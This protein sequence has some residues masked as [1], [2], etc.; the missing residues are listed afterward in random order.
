MI[1]EEFSEY[2][3]KFNDKI[4]AD[5]LLSR[6]LKIKLLEEPKTLID[7]IINKEICI[8]L[9]NQNNFPFS[10]RSKTGTN[11]I[12]SLYNYAQSYEQQK[13]NRWLHNLKASDFNNINNQK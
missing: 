9:N 12:E 11:L 13:F 6:W 7:K 8:S 1:L 5:L 3:K 4:P 2:L 10:G